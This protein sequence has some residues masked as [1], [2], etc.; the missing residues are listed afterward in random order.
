MRRDGAIRQ[1]SGTS[2]FRPMLTWAIV[3]AFATGFSLPALAEVITRKDGRKIEGQIVREDKDTVTIQTVYGTFRVSR[4]QI[5]SISGRRAISQ[6]EREGQEAL[7]AGDLDRALAKFRESLKEA[8]TAEERKAIED[9]IA[10]VNKRIQE[11]EE[12][13]FAAQLA[14]ADR[15]IQ[16]KRFEDAMV[17]LDNLLKLNAEN[18]AT[19]KMIQQRKGQLRMA[20]AA[21]YVEYLLYTEAADAYRKAMELMPDNP[22][23]YLRMARLVQ[24]RGGRD[25]GAIDYYVKGIERALRT[26]TEAS[27][28]DEYYEL[29]KAYL[30]AANASKDPTHYLMEGIKCLLI[31]ARDGGTSYPFVGSQLEN[32]FVQLSKTNYDMDAMIK[33]LQS[34]LE[35]NPNAQKA[36]WIL[37]EV[38]SKKREYQKVVEQLEKIEADV[39]ASGGTMPEELYYRL[40]LAYQ[41]LPSPDRGKILAAFE[42]EIRQNKLNYMALIKAAE[43]HAAKGTYE[44]ALEY[45]NLAIAL[46]KERPEAYLVVAE[47]YRRRNLPDDMQ[48]SRRY[49]TMA[50]N[51]KSDFQQARIK[52]AQIEIEQQRKTDAP[53]YQPAIEML[54]LAIQGLEAMD[55]SQRTDED[56]KAKAE[57]ILWL[58][59]IEN[60][61][62]NP[63][64][65]ATKVKQ[66]LAEYPNFARAYSLQGQIQVALELYDEAKKSYAKAIELDPDIVETYML[67]GSLCQN[68]LK[69]FQEAVKYYRAYLD[70]HGTDV[71]RITRWIGECERAISAS[72]LST[73]ATSET[74]ATDTGSTETAKKL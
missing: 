68:Y 52:L 46:R 66:A 25:V 45:C 57:A 11:R 56:R 4:D 29:G 49:L 36:R 5:A 71:E 40:G 73:S 1:R 12:K 51:I 50:L 53:N 59:E 22:E 20:E 26:R 3:A 35:M 24:G 23:P 58:G 6:N 31:V 60:D 16:D 44:D 67:M 65:A 48:N 10:D 32:G 13:R 69:S 62:K 61:R 15:L 9:L 38:Y 37:A 72:A 30:R 54:L 33:M 41:A 8:K 74:K 7:A 17:E 28:M 39:K 27:L 42:N 70:H 63:R 55:K 34:T 21:Y 64:E 14:T 47:V 2:R 43:I 19:A 18:N